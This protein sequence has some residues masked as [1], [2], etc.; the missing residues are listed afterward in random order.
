MHHDVYSELCHIYENLRIF[1]T[2]THLKPDKYSGPSRRFKTEFF[3][4]IIKN[5]NYFSKTFHLRSLIGFWIRLSLNKYSLTSRVTS[6]YVLHD[7]YSEPYLLSK[8]QKYSG[9]FTS[10]SDDIFSHIVAYLEPCLTL[11]YSDPYHIQ[12]PS[13]FRTQDIFRTLS[14]HILA[15]RCGTLTFWEPCHSQNFA[16]IQNFGIFKTRRIF[17]ILFI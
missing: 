4:K 3:A 2:L 9:I 8:I 10:Y 16:I 14:R 15:E 1:R 7:T 17:R 5:Y 12:N 13:I 11:A 6:H